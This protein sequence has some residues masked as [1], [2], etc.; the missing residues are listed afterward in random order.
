MIFALKIQVSF[1][2]V[3]LFANYW[4]SF[5]KAYNKNK[6]TD[7]WLYEMLMSTQVHTHRERYNLICTA[8]TFYNTRVISAPLLL[9]GTLRISV[10]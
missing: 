7:P 5:L 10:S 9:L 3:R 4:L 8:Y 1:T 2:I 6:Q